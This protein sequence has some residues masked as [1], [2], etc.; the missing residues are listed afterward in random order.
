MAISG[1]LYRVPFKTLVS[2]AQDLIVVYATATKFGAVHAVR[3]DQTTIDTRV[4]LDVSF[5]RL[6]AVV[7]PGSGGTTAPLN[8]V[9][10]ADVAATLTA[11]INDIV[12]AET[13][14][15]AVVLAPMGWNLLT[16]LIWMPAISGRP[17]SF[18]LGEAFVVSLDE[19]PPAEMLVSGFLEV[20]EF[21]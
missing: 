16:G 18:D 7:T 5:K 9:N 12:P 13:S 19:D 15:T 1:R 6:P 2:E 21:L 14:G 4:N 3:L 20:E 10:P 11:R 17:L 8:A